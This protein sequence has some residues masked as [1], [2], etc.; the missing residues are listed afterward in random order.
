MSIAPWK[1]PTIIIRSGMHSLEA[2][3]M[4]N[5]N[6]RLQHFFLYLIFW[7]ISAQLNKCV[8][9]YPESLSLPELTYQ[10]RSS[11]YSD[12]IARATVFLSKFDKKAEAFQIQS[13][14]AN[15]KYETDLTDE[16]LKQVI[17]IGEEISS[18][19]LQSSA[20]AS[21][22][23][24]LDLPEDLSRQITL[25]RRS[26]EPPQKELRMDIKKLIGEMT[27][28]YGSA[29]VQKRDEKLNLTGNVT[30][31][32]L[33]KIFKTS[34]DMKELNWAWKGWRDAVGPPTKRHFSSLVDLLNIGA[35][36]HG[37]ID[38]G[39]YLRREYEMSDLEETLD[40]VWTEIE[41]L[42]RELHAYVRYRLS[43]VYNISKDGCVPA[44]I[45]GDLY[46][47]NWENIFELVQ[48]KE[49]S[50]TFDVTRE[51]KN[52]KYTVKK[53]FQLAES[54]FTSVG[55]DA[56]PA[57]FWNRSVLTKEK[58]KEMVC[59]A[60]AWDVGKEDVRYVAMHGKSYGKSSNKRTSH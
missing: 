29:K 17:D 20:N 31:A 40:H 7:F 3:V 50:K 18:F 22:I 35:R 55:L 49:T 36:E 39:D 43:S 1:V 56:M 48:P 2:N 28:I 45:L 33:S 16:H 58:D 41:P 30:Q 27:K 15:W 13:G 44:S 32:D 10:S 6:P 38:Y 42:Y 4:S 26:S 52:Q 24:T 34:R 12:D 23:K 60:S 5:F 54:F 8:P 57:T 14:E 59:H 21:K 19:Y 25:I 51:L 9:L 11:N 37:W 53:I 47:Q 46:A